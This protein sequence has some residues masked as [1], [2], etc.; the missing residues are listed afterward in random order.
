MYDLVGGGFHR[1]SVDDRWLVPHFEKMLY[2]NALLVPAYLH[3]WLVTGEERYREVVEETIDVR[4]ARAAP[5][6]RRLRLRPG[7]RHRR[8]R[9]AD[10]HVDRRTRRRSSGSTRRLLQPFE[11]G[12]SIVRGELDAGRARAAARDPRASDRSP[13][14]TTRR[15]RP[16]TG[17]RSRRSPRRPGGSTATTGS[18]RR[19]RSASSCSATAE[20]TGRSLAPDRTGT[21]ATSGRRVPR[22]LRER[23]QRPARAPR[24]DRRPPLAARGT[25][26]RAASR[27]SSSATTSTAASSSRRTTASGSSTR[28]K[29]LD[30]DPTPVGQLDARLGAVPARPGSGATTSSRAARR[31]CLRL[32]APAIARAAGGLRL[33]ALRARPP[34]RA[35]ARARDRRAR[36]AP[37]SRALRS[38][39]SSRAPSSPFGPDRGRCRCS[40]ARASSTACRPS[41]SASDSRAARR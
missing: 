6:G 34:P 36:P 21:A 37:R 12:R 11:H 18:T 29:D 24:R 19:S 22:R 30:D 31:R 2:D 5:P 40:P 10:V 25:S 38:R 33:G 17:S 23:R 27:S 41:T 26:A 8:R 32:V 9:G 16:G 1:Y 13:S 3:A 39:P 7:R 15:S 20:R 28:T 4:P 14:A 35:A